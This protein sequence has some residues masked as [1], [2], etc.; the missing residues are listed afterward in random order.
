MGPAGQYEHLNQEEKQ[1]GR[2]Q[3]RLTVVGTGLPAPCPGSAPSA[4]AG[5][6][7]VPGVGA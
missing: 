2:A 6:V 7:E 5:Q 1:T 4:S 3:R